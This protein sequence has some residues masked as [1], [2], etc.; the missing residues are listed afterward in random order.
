MKLLAKLPKVDDN[1]LYHGPT[2]RRFID[3]PGGEVVVVAVMKTKQIVTDYQTGDVE[4][5]VYISKIE[6][7]TEEGDVINALGCAGRAKGERIGETLPIDTS[8]GEVELE[9][10]RIEKPTRLE[11]AN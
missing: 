9:R 4:P 11:V 1:G 3:N 6:A 10:Y 2:R 5:V 8:T 7:I